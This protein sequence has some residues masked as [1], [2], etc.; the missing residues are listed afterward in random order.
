MDR[1]AKDRNG[2]VVVNLS[3]GPSLNPVLHET[4][5]A[6]RTEAARLAQQQVGDTFQVFKVD[7]MPGSFR[8]RQRNEWRC[9]YKNELRAGQMFVSDSY[10]SR[11]ELIDRFKSLTTNEVV[12]IFS[13]PVY[14]PVWDEANLPY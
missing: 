1:F 6:A 12:Q 5:T 2:F 9:V 14:E 10:D 4:E 3:R 13:T 11:Q 8:Y 7:A